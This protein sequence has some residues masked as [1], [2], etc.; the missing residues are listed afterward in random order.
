V[1]NP[2]PGQIKELIGVPHYFARE[3][4]AALSALGKT[5]V[6]RAQL[7]L[8]GADFELK[9]GSDRDEWLILTMMLRRLTNGRERNIERPV[10]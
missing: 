5:E 9:G 1:S 6:S 7:T 10:A 3:Y 2:T 4:Q 8:L